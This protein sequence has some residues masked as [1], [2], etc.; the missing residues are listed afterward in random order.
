V[1]V[2]VCVCLCV[3]VSQ[4]PVSPSCT[5]APDVAV[6]ASL[7]TAYVVAA[8]PLLVSRVVYCAMLVGKVFGAINCS[9]NDVSF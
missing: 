4:L 8:L 6:D 3:Y 5:V 7:R 2:R 1:C 9:T